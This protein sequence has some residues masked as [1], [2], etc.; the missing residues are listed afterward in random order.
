MALLAVVVEPSMLFRSRI[1]AMFRAAGWRVIGRAT[2]SDARRDIETEPPSMLVTSL[3]LGSF[4]GTH[5]VYLAKLTN[6]AVACLVYGDPGRGDEARRAGAIYVE[7]GTLFNV[8]PSILKS[9]QPPP[10]ENV[11]LLSAHEARLLD[12]P[13]RSRA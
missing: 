2:L 10:G 6:P 12:F 5:L 9:M 7:R 1:E 3:K 13:S 4:N 8:L 11:G